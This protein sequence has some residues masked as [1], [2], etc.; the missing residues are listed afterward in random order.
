MIDFSEAAF[1]DEIVHR[2]Q[3]RVAPGNVWLGD[4][5]HLNGGLV[6]LDEHSIVDLTKTE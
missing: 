1:V 4:S 5:K 6:K 2:L 3:V